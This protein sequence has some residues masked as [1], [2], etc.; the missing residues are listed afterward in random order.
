MAGAFGAT[1]LQHVFGR[2]VT[3]L[4]MYPGPRSALMSADWHSEGD[5]HVQ[6]LR[7]RL[8]NKVR[9]K[10]VDVGDAEVR[11]YCDARMEFNHVEL[12]YINGRLRSGELVTVLENPRDRV[13]TAIGTF[14]RL[15]GFEPA[16]EAES[17]RIAQCFVLMP[18]AEALLPI[19]DDHITEVVNRLGL[20]C[21]RA[22]RI[23][24][25]RPIMDDVLDSVHRAR[26]VIAD[27]THANPNV[28]Y[29]LG[30]CHALGKDVILITQDAEVPFDVRHIR[31]IRY[32]FTPRGMRSFE[33]SLENS[34]RAILA[35]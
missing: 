10:I 14:D 35:S 17:G 6:E 13:E 15:R 26:L 24:S 16:I 4:Y 5:E 1:R 34:I 28:F 12:A 32:E 2:A 22:D 11:A 29:E 27:L 8:L 18:F 23:F 25:N 3:I 31:H 33:D 20:S 30:I 21:L 9:T 7:R 19:Y